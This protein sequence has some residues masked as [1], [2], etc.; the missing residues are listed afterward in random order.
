[1]HLIRFAIAIVLLAATPAIAQTPSNPDS[2]PNIAVPPGDTPE[3]QDEMVT[4]RGCLE[5]EI[6]SGTAGRLILKNRAGRQQPGA[7][8]P[9]AATTTLDTYYVE[10][11]DDRVDLESKVGHRVEVVGSLR[12]PDVAPDRRTNEGITPSLPSGGS[13]METLPRP[14][15][16]PP[17]KQTAGGK[18]P[19]EEDQMTTTEAPPSSTLLVTKIRSLEATCQAD[20]GGEA[21]R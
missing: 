13:G 20:E 4:V 19:G 2:P 11:K 10:A 12:R 7:Q 15:D 18:R 8:L 14:T 1:M 21:R 6:G 16:Q 17:D 9:G 3:E 5:R